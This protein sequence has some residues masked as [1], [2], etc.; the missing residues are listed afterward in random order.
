[1]QRTAQVAQAGPTRTPLLQRPIDVT[2]LVAGLV[3]VVTATRFALHLSVTVGTLI[4]VV[5]LPVWLSQLHRFRG[6]R[7]LMLLTAMAALS[8]L[9]LT[10]LASVD[11]RTTL[12]V[13]LSVTVNLLNFGMGVGIL[14]WA[15]TLLSGPVI[16]MLTGFGLLLGMPTDGRFA[17]NP[18]RFGLATP[19]TVLLLAAAWYTGRRWLEVATA[20]LLAAAC[21]LTGARSPFAML[22]LAAILVAW[23][24]TSRPGT[25]AGARL[26][27]VVFSSLLVLGIYQVGQGLILDGYLGEQAQQRTEHQVEASGSLLLGARPEAGATVALMAHRPWGFGAGTAA[28]SLDIMVAKSGMADLNYDPDNGYVENYM[29][30]RAIVLHSTAG[31]L[32]AG[33]G[34]IGLALAGLLS[35]FVIRGLTGEVAG[36]TASALTV[37]LAVRSLWDLGFGPFYSAVPLLVLSIAL[38]LPRSDSAAFGV[39]AL[40]RAAGRRHPE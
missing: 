18:W 10:E 38:L 2:A 30:G 33:F 24:A 15:R 13:T 26:R 40:S 19:V 11:H 28:N 17:E 14:L 23:V 39:A 21:A 32:W 27:V 5:L 4:G 34:L 25:R 8:G 36:R 3:V 29:F 35:F 1:M 12:T 22:L 16:G 7:V 9:W 20:L 37:Y 31:D 6:A